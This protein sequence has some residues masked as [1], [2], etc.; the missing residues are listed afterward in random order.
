MTFG[1]KIGELDVSFITQQVTCI[2]DS[3]YQILWKPCGNY[4]E[5]LCNTCPYSGDYFMALQTYTSLGNII[6][7]WFLA[8]S[9]DEPTISTEIIG[10]KNAYIATY[11]YGLNGRILDIRFFCG[12]TSYDY[13]KTICGEYQT[14]RY[15]LDIYSSYACD[16]EPT[17][18]SGLKVGFIILIGYVI[19]Y[20]HIVNLFV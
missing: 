19:T 20:T 12:E 8:L 18:N 2:F 16:V 6:N 17:N 1:C 15:Y 10:D 7:C 4:A 9:N 5:C 14:L 3:D 11:D 13:G